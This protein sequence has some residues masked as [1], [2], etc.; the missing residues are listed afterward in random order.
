MSD[1]KK[2]KIE[3]E[4]AQRY[5]TNVKTYIST[6]QYKNLDTSEKVKA[7]NKIRNN[8]RDDIKVEYGLAKPKKRKRSN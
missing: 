5:A 4:F 2:N 3:K 1:E 8:I 7:L 6:T